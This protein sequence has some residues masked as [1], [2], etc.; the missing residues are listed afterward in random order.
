MTPFFDVSIDAQTYLPLPEDTGG[1]STALLNADPQKVQT[2]AQG[3]KKGMDKSVRGISLCCYSL[4]S[5]PPKNGTIDDEDCDNSAECI[6]ADRA[7]GIYCTFLR[8]FFSFN[9]F[10]GQAFVLRFGMLAS[11]QDRS[12]QGVLRPALDQCCLARS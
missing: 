8:A 1:Q 9:D 10:S 4:C 5:I 7:V 6:R 11:V 2:V 12:L 3:I